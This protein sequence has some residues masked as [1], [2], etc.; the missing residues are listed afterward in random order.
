MK[1]KYKADRPI[2]AG[3]T[4]TAGGVLFTGDVDGNLYAFE[5]RGT[6]D[7]KGSPR[8]IVMA[9]NPSG[10]ARRDT[11]PEANGHGLVSQQ[12]ALEHGEE[13]FGQFCSACH[14]ARGEQGVAQSKKTTADALVAFIKNPT[15]AM[16]KLH[17]D[18]LDERE[19]QNVAAYVLTLQRG[20]QK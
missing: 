16:P 3:I 15:G 1:W 6:F 5:S 2:V 10:P 17:P 9:L 12:T 19:V 7:T 8:M 4:P 20:R 14:G 11:L 18:P 13:I